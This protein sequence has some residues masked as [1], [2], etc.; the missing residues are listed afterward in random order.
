MP[1]PGRPKQTTVWRAPVAMPM[2]GS[3]QR[4]MAR[5]TSWLVWRYETR[6]LASHRFSGVK[7]RPLHRRSGEWPRLATSCSTWRITW[8]G[9]S[10]SASGWWDFAVTGTPFEDAASIV[11]ICAGGASGAEMAVWVSL[12]GRFGPAPAR[13]RR[14]L[15]YGARSRRIPWRTDDHH[16]SA[17]RATSSP[18]LDPGLLLG[19]GH[20]RHHHDA[21]AGDQ[22]DGAPAAGLGPGH[23]AG[24]GGDDWHAGRLRRA[25]GAGPALSALIVSSPAFAAARFAAGFCEAQMI[26]MVGICLAC[27]RDAER[28][29]GVVLL[30][31]GLAGVFTLLSLLPGVADGSGIWYG[32]ALL[33]ALLAVGAVRVPVLMPAAQPDVYVGRRRGRA[34]VWLAW[35]VFVGVYSVQAG[36]WAVS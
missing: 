25:A 3:P 30:L 34:E 35:G 29:W 33:A 10:A 11:R 9:T 28:L 27:H 17:A 21:A 16:A 12:S 4:C 5:L 14:M 19:A 18:H 13:R 31:S 1:R 24:G 36:V 2:A 32:L 6:K 22:C 26:V 7:P 15:G 8:G 23:H 20:R